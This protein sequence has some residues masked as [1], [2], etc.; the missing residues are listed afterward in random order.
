M[1]EIQIPPYFICPISL[2]MMKDPVTIST[3]ITYDRENIE[4]WIFSAKNNT[5]PVTKQSLITGIE[6]TPNVTL[7]RFIQSWCTINASHGIERFPTP[8]PPVSKPQI[9]KLLKEAKSPMMQMKSLKTLRS[10]ASENDANK[11]CMESAGAMEFLASII[12]NNNSNE[13]FEEEEEGFMSTKDEALSILYQLKLSEQG[14]KSLIMSGNGEFIESLTH[15]MQHGSYESRA[16]AVMLMKDMFEVSTPTLLLSLKQEFFTQVVQVLRDEISQKATK[17]SLQVLVHACPFGRN[18]VKAAEAGTIRVLVDLLL[19][20]SEKRVC[21]LMLILLDQLCLS[22]E[23]RAELLNHPGGLAIVSKKILRVS[24]VGSERAIKILHS[25]SKFSST[26]SVVQEMLSLGVVAK[27][28]LVL[29]VDCGS[30][31]K[32]RAR[33]ILKFHAKAWSNSPCIP[34]NLLSS[35]PF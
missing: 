16:Y 10:I 11:R 33:E 35:Y 14:L 12:I 5:C 9:I 15:V 28:C 22:A 21:E 1:E 26:P 24:K 31:S 17:A 6:L 13:V 25:I 18:R 3:G 2:E 8:K 19:D 29:Q 30:K 32:E 7:R 4:K 20:S 34:N 23:G 27:L